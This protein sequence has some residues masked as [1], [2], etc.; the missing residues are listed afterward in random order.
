[1]RR[2]VP[3]PAPSPKGT[4][5]DARQLAIPGSDRP[6]E[7]H[8]CLPVPGMAPPPKERRRAKHR[9]RPARGVP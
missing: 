5:D 1:M 9:V 2:S 4:D 7:R 8:L 6:R 3:D